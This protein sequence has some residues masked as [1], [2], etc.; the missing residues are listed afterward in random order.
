MMGERKRG[1]EGMEKERN[2]SR[3]RNGGD[4][5][6]R[7]KHDIIRQLSLSRADDTHILPMLN[8]QVNAV[9]VI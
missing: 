8:K 5:S 9:C 7:N 4:M 1:G 2:R 3:R 6:A